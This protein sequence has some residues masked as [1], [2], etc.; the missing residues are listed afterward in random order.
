[1]FDKSLSPP[2]NRS[3]IMS[4]LQQDGRRGKTWTGKEEE[5]E[6][7]KKDRGEQQGVDEGGG[8]G[9]RE[10][11]ARARDFMLKLLGPEPVKEK[12]VEDD[13]TQ[14]VEEETTVS[15]K[16]KKKRRKKNTY[17]TFLNSFRS[18]K[19]KKERIEKE[20]RDKARLEEKIKSQVCIASKIEKL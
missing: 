5:V 16:K 20:R 6:T 4:E 11:E 15:K 9:E 19:S 8:E 18:K 3:P 7:K 10:R 1:M 13:V 14:E 17:R 12:G 2:P